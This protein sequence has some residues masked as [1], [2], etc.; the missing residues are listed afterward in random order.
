MDERLSQLLAHVV[1]DFIATGEP[2]GSQSL[3][4]DHGLDVSSATVRNWFGELE[5]LGYVTQPHTSGGRIP[6]E[7]GYQ[8]YV[9]TLMG[10]RPLGRKDRNEIE[11]AAQGAQDGERRLKAM[12][13]VA[14]TGVGVAVVLGMN[15]ADTFYT[16]L[17]QLFSQPE[18]SE[19]QHLM[20]LGSMLDR[21]DELLT[22]ARGQ[23][24]DAPAI[25]VG[26][27]CPFGSMCGSV[28]L[29]LPDG[30]LAGIFGPMRMDYRSAIAYLEAMRD[31]SSI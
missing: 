9:D 6:T 17:T 30:S 16:G 1:E 3:V 25:L 29:T 18:F 2:V 15:E 8:F 21:L 19:S 24:F 4:N 22:R 23:R 13:K 28:L 26:S 27:Q 12:A 14:A 11:Q 31:L 20:S 5:D 7:K 10:R